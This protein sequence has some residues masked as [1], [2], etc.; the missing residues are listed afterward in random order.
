MIE[1]ENNFSIFVQNQVAPPTSQHI[2][3]EDDY[4]V[5]KHELEKS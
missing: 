1:L 2:L 5:Y 4:K 3:K